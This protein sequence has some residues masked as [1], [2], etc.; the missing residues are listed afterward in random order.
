V[1]TDKN[2]LLFFLYY[3][4]HKDISTDLYIDMWKE[5]GEENGLTAGRRDGGSEW[6][7]A[8]VDRRVGLQHR[9]RHEVAHGRLGWDSKTSC[10]NAFR[11]TKNIS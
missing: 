10:V 8:H 11:V 4:V 3:Y 7:T 5:G 9:L 1:R 6:L 2:S